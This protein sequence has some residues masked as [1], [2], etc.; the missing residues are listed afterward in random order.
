MSKA[1]TLDRMFS[2]LV[3]ATGRVRSAMDALALKAIQRQAELTQ[4]PPAFWVSMGLMRAALIH[5]RNC[6]DLAMLVWTQRD[7]WRTTVDTCLQD[8]IVALWQAHHELIAL[9]PG[10][11]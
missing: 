6:Q 8:E 11:G 2:D 5:H 1:T 10:D 3:I 7:H 4:M 9:L